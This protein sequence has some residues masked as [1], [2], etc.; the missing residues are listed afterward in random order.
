MKFPDGTA[1][2]S[3]MMEHSIQLLVLSPCCS[4]LDVWRSCVI[5]DSSG[6]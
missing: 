6:P 1:A 2:L 4:L 3:G 5:Y